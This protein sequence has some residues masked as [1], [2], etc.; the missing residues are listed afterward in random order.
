M[1]EPEKLADE[2]VEPEEEAP[3]PGVV[4]EEENEGDQ[5]AA[6]VKELPQAVTL[7]ETRWTVCSRGDLL[8]HAVATESPS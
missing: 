2:E 5:E 4:G 7:E 6:E 8:D 3:E 1:A